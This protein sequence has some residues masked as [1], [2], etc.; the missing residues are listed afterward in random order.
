[1]APWL[2]RALALTEPAA[3]PNEFRRDGD[4]W[5]V[6]FAGRA[7]RLTDTKGLRDIAQLL[8]RPGVGVHCSELIAAAERVRTG[9]AP[10]ARE[11]A[12]AGLSLGS[13]GSEVLDERAREAYRA[14]LSDLQE[15]LED[16]ESSNDPERAARARGE[17]DFLAGE[18]AS[19]YGLG[20]RPRKVADP[21]E[22]A[23]K[24]VAERIRA[25]IGR[26]R[27]AHPELGRHLGNSIRTGTFCSYT[28]EAP[29]DWKL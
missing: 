2:E 4:V 6:A 5:T 9:P 7:A 1:M 25:A 21:T 10:S 16:A 23:R 28:P 26:V 3:E 17:L 20:G 24:A 14:R 18:L 22:R 27:T 13:G 19:A 12:E 29:I 8:A 11:A 15:E